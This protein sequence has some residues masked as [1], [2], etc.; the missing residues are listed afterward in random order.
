M[1]EGRYFAAVRTA[2]S[3]AVGVKHLGDNPRKIAIFGSG[4]QGESHAKILPTLFKSIKEVSIYSPTKKHRDE[5]VKLLKKNLKDIKVT[6]AKNSKIAV[7]DADVIVCATSSK[8]PVFDNK[9]IKKKVLIIGVGGMKGDQEIPAQ[10]VRESMIV[11]DS[12]KNIPMYDELAKAEN[13]GHKLKMSGEIGKVIL[14]K[15]TLENKKIVFKHHGLPVTDAA[16]AESILAEGNDRN[17][18][19]LK[20]VEEAYVRIKKYVP[21]TPIK[22][23]KKNV[24]LK[25]ENKQPIVKGFKTRGAASAMT[26]LKAGDEVMTSALGTHGFAVGYIGKK[27]GIKTTCMLIKNPPVDAENKMKKLVDRVVYG[28]ETFVETE[29]MAKD[30]AEKNHM[31]FLHPYNDP[32]VIAGQGTVA[33]ELMEQLPKLNTIYVPIGG[34]GLISGISIVLKALNPKIRIV[35]VQPQKMHAMVSAVEAKKI[36]SV[37]NEKSCAEKLAVNLNPQ[38][39]TFKIIEKGVDDFILVSEEEIRIAIKEIYKKTGEIAEGAGAI[40][41]AAYLKD[42]KKS[43]VAVC[44]VSGGNI[45]EEKFKEIVCA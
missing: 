45:S 5:L 1:I 44:V 36:I 18:P 42:K 28:A 35:G 19:F 38:T 2:L 6:S 14:T 12:E 24:Y 20:D 15:P 41:Y 7:K 13:G 25:L 11:V 23:I 4:V 27:L 8:I 29:L 40:S 37:P 16:L 34:G 26:L 39:I 32:N 22:Q 3:S 21:K 9:D 33:L 31:C 43:G 30:Y 17:L 10:A